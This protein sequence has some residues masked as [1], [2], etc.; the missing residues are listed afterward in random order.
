M[1]TYKYHD[2]VTLG[3]M[4]VPHDLEYATQVARK[5]DTSLETRHVGRWAFQTDDDSGW[6]LVDTSPTWQPVIPPAPV[7]GDIGKALTIVSDGAGFLKFAWNVP[8]STTTL[9]DAYNNDG[10]AATITVDNGYV[11]WAL[12]DENRVVVDCSNASNPLVN[13]TTVRFGHVVSNGADTWEVYRSG[14]D[15][16]AVYADLTT[17]HLNLSGDFDISGDDAF[18]A[19]TDVVSITAGASSDMTLGARGVSKTLNDGTNTTFT[20]GIASKTSIFGALNDLDSRISSESLWNRSGT[21]LYPQNSGDFIVGG[22]GSGD[23]LTLNSTTHATKGTINLG[24]TAYV[25]EVNYR[26][27][28]GTSSPSSVVDIEGAGDLLELSNGTDIFRFNLASNVLALAGISG[29]NRIHSQLDFT[30]AGDVGIGTTSPQSTLDIRGDIF[31]DQYAVS[32]QNTLLGIDAAGAGNMTGLRNT[33]IAYQSGYSI[34]GGDDTVAIGHQALYSN[35]VG[36]DNVAI[37]SSA[38]KY[39]DNGDY[40]TAVGTLALWKNTVSRNTALGWQAGKNN[41][42]GSSLVAIGNDAAA[43]Q[44]DGFGNVCVGDSA[45]CYNVS[46]SDNVIVGMSAGKGVIGGSTHNN[47][48][49]I[50]YRAGYKV[51]TGSNNTFYGCSAG[52][53]ITTGNNNILVGYKAGD[54]LTT[55]SGNIIIGYDIDVVDVAGNDQLNIGNLIYGNPSGYSFVVTGA[56]A[57]LTLGARAVTKTLNDA[58][59]ATFTGGIASKTSI[60]GALNDLDSRISSE[61]LWDRSGT[62]LYPQNSGDFIVGGV[63][64][65][66]DLTLN[67]TTHATKGTINLGGTAYVDEV[68]YR[69]GVGT[70]SPAQK[71][72]IEG[73]AGSPASG[74]TVQNGIVRIRN[75]SN[76]NALDIGQ[77]TGTP[78]G[79]WLQATDVSDLGTYY[80]LLLN[81]NGGNVGIGTINPDGKLHVQVEDSDAS[82]T[83]GDFVIKGDGGKQLAA[84]TMPTYVWIQSH[85]SPLSIN[86]IGNNVGIGTTIPLYGLDVRGTTALMNAGSDGTLSTAV[87]FGNP[88]APS[89]QNHRIRTSTSAGSGGN[90]LQ[91]EVSDGTTGSYNDDQ[92]VLKGTGFVGIGESSPDDE[93]HV[94]GATAQIDIESTSGNAGLKIQASTGNDP[95]VD[96]FNGTSLITAI[97]Y[98]TSDS[99]FRINTGSVN[100]VINPSG[101]N[102]GI[103]DTDPNQQLTINGTMDMAEQSAAGTDNA[104]Y[105]QWWV[106][107]EAPNEAWFT[108]DDGNDYRLDAVNNISSR[109]V[110]G[111]ST[112]STSWQATDVSISVPPGTWIFYWTL[113]GDG[114]S[115]GP[116]MQWRIR[117]I[118]SGNTY[119]ERMDQYL[120]YSGDGSLWQVQAGH[121]KVT[122]TGSTKT[123]RVEF[124][125]DGS[126]TTVY[127]GEETILTAVRAD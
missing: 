24:G 19:F 31:T 99:L 27:G 21:N 66:D 41:T 49:F 13:G 25:D 23:D 34:T 119:G 114:S 113:Y 79:T 42:T 121:A 60:F 11:T 84:G 93:L 10:G 26:F 29:V 101:G 95:Y 100:C 56:S 33:L 20:G 83:S 69:F 22:V 64:S 117:N 86:P 104:G 36:D 80:P 50:G 91:I 103:N 5:G 52:E 32:P 30:V 7:V 3:N 43:S 44:Q 110:S 39:N 112:E 85:G 16:L 71:L 98:D 75:A 88:S 107:N 116:D 118:T 72:D 63:G 28:V 8:A 77:P 45:G 68:N 55:G 78:W 115:D 87:I 59:N 108:D 54:N 81:P 53:N 74:G 15:S 109:S 40:C 120:N 97:Y 92:F 76:D 73:P 58:S 126:G 46:G 62:N 127:Y 65:G 48:T 82:A 96:F 9:D 6:K 37:G 122:L 90:L 102:V 106:K 57:D 14:V 111:G 1:V 18:L 2:V 38:L 89:T 12:D 124:R 61:S 94:K 125:L 105:G 123:V 51:D 70:S 17:F 67:S 4:H 47:N 35:T